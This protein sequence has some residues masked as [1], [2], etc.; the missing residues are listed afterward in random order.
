MSKINNMNN[1]IDEVFD[2][3]KILNS[4][5]YLKQE[6][7]KIILVEKL[8]TLNLDKMKYEESTEL[9]ISILDKCREYDFDANIVELVLERWS[10]HEFDVDGVF[11]DLLGNGSCSLEIL[12]YLRRVFKMCCPLTILDTHIRTRYGTGSCFT[13]VANRALKTYE[14][15]NLDDFEW[16]QLIDSCEETKDGYELDPKFIDRQNYSIT[17]DNKDVI[18]Y[19]K[20]KMNLNAQKIT[21]EKP[22][23][24]INS[25]LDSNPN[26][27]IEDSN[28]LNKLMQYIKLDSL[29]LDSDL[30]SDSDSK[31]LNPNLNPILNAQINKMNNYIEDF[32]KYGPENPIYND[33]EIE[34]CN[35]TEGPCKMFSCLCREQQEDDEIHTTYEDILPHDVWFT[36]HCENCSKSIDNYRYALRFPLEKGGFDGCFCS[37]S[38]MKKSDKYE[39]NNQCKE[40][41][42]SIT[43]IGIY[44]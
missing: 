41:E 24:I 16:R 7:T 13:L 3:L 43:E 10:G 36:G 31:N 19:I 18:E 34:P 22:K 37:F 14:V 5:S 17:R 8:N 44:E 20:F 1:S 30:D 4:L 26:S 21:A 28:L 39:Y 15:E 12:R 27:K 25:N 42:K 29:D 11:G 2:E 6:E 38:C 33:S 23:W 35:M 9:L 32:R 40:L